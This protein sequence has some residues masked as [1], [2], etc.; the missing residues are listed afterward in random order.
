M[1]NNNS[2]SQEP[3]GAVQIAV[4]HSF[5]PRA[6]AKALRVFADAGEMVGASPDADPELRGCLCFLKAQ[7]EK[8]ANQLE[9]PTP[10]ASA[11]AAIAA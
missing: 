2:P 6:M 9:H 7:F 4:D 10:P 3:P 11:S 8:A 1:R 5:S